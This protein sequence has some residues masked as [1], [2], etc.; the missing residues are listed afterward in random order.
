[1]ALPE[2]TK[3]AIQ[4]ARNKPQNVRTTQDR[5][6]LYLSDKDWVSA[7]ELTLNVTHKFSSRLS[8]LSVLGIKY[9]KRLS[10]SRPHGVRY[11]DYRLK[12]MT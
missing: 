8:E 7:R 6:L 10:P 1:M 9:E 2:L 4:D 11:Y 3:K 5:V 12:E